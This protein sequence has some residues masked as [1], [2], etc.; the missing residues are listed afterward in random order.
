MRMLIYLGQATWSRLDAR[1]CRR[2]ASRV[3]M[4]AAIDACEAS[5]DSCCF[6]ALQ[7][8]FDRP[9]SPAKGASPDSYG[10]G[11]LLGRA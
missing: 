4:P 6:V 8:Q 3:C 7:P 11:L 1:R 10:L 5:V 9:L 2:Q